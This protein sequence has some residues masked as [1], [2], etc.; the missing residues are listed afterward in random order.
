M[1]S[2]HLPKESFT[3]S[4]IT[5]VYM[6][7][8]SMSSVQSELSVHHPCG[9]TRMNVLITCCPGMQN[10]RGRTETHNTNI[11][12]CSPYAPSVLCQHKLFSSPQHGLDETPKGRS[13]TDYVYQRFTSASDLKHTSTVTPT[14]SAGWVKP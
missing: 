9:L 14:L 5:L 3:V 2:K 13:D 7:Y 10:I 11:R 8:E 1:P 12:L 4:T 6:D